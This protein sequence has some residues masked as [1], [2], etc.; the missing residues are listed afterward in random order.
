MKENNHW[1][2]AFREFKRLQKRNS[3]QQNEEPRDGD[4]L[5]LTILVNEHW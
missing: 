5:D 4:D 1:T 2:D 3:S